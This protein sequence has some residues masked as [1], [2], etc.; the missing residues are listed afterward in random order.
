MVGT[1]DYVYDYVCY[2]KLKLLHGCNII[3]LSVNVNTFSFPIEV[4]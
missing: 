3:C 4:D 1:L 2:P